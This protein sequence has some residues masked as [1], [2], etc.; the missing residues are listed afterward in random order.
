MA[1]KDTRKA[2]ETKNEKIRNRIGFSRMEKKYEWKDHVI[3]MG[4]LLGLAFWVNRNV[5]IKG[6]YMDDLYL[7]SC[8]GEQ[9]FFQ[10]VF[11]IGSTRFRFLYYL[12]AWLEMAFVGS[13]VSWF[14]P[15]NI[16]INTMVAW[17][18]YFM[19]RSLSRSKAVGF[20]CGAMYL[21]TRMAYYQIGQ[22]LGL[23]ETMALWMAIGILWCLYRYLNEERR[24]GLFYISCA[25]YFGVCFVHERYMVLFPLLLLALAVKR[26]RNLK[27]WAS[28]IG[29]FLVMQLIRF[30]AIGTVLPAGTGRTQVAE[31]FSIGQAIVYAANQIGYIFGWNLGPEHLNGCPWFVTPFWVKGLVILGDVMVLLL[32]LGFLLRIVREK[33]KAKRTGFFINAGL[34]VFFIGACIA[35]S[36]VTIRVEMRWIYVS[37]TAALLF[38]AYMYGVLTEGVSPEFYLKR[39]WPWG[40]LIAGYVLFMFPAELFYRSCFPTLYLWP[41]QSRYNS[42]AE[43]TREK[44]GEEVEGKTIYILGNTYEVSDFDAKTFFKV[45]QKDRMAELTQVVFIDSIQDMGLVDDNTLVLKEDPEHNAYVDITD[46]VKEIKVH[47]DYG[48]YDY[49]DWMDEHSEITVMSGDEGVIEL[50]FVFPGILEGGE[51]ISITRENGQQERIPLRTNVVEHEIQAEPWQLVHLKFDYNFYTQDAREQRS[52]SKL[53]TLV[54]INVR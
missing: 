39:F 1:S 47:V 41:E 28:A 21:V 16:L 44:Y 46:T 40:A 25:L 45:F 7:W 10:Y 42:L 5:E 18:I 12:A 24:E 37:Y 4:I 52:D 3:F 23:M 19:G 8:F 6:L 26:C 53:A 30:L 17:T 54:H 49:D 9:S 48:Y 51:I 36:S 2:D 43:V 35:A 38:M 13:H 11:P 50:E 33:E 32:A 20:V 27:A 29:A 14:V 15:I 22:V 31:T 34:F